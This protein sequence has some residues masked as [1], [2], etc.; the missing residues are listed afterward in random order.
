MGYLCNQRKTKKTMFIGITTQAPKL[1]PYQAIQQLAAMEAIASNPELVVSVCQSIKCE[2]YIDLD[3]AT[4]I[5]FDELCLDTGM[6]WSVIAKC[7][8]MIK[9]VYLSSPLRL[10]P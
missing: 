10:S 9:A 6:E 2:G 1:T 8:R 3:R 4:G 5:I 7:Q